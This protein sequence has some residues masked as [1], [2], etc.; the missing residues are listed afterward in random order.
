MR[1]KENKDNLET[2]DL[3]RLVRAASFATSPRRWAEAERILGDRR[4]DV[5]RKEDAEEN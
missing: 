5:T 1:Q 4:V 3:L 2:P